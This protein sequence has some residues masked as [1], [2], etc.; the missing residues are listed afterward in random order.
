MLPRA[1]ANLRSA[2]QCS[3]TRRAAVGRQLPEELL[4]AEEGREAAAKAAT[5]EQAA[6]ERPDNEG[7]VAEL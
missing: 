4:A 2:A 7:M 6:E 5:E 3:A 1:I